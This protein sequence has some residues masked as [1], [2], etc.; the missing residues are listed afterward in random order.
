MIKINVTEDG[1]QKT[2]SGKPGISLMET[3]R[4]AGIEGIV[5][6][7]GGSMSCASCHVFVDSEWLTAMG[8]VS[9]MESDMLD[10]TATEREAGSR[11]SCQIM[12]TDTMDGLSVTVPDE[13]L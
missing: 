7:C 1:Q 4:N 8:E 2:V 5:A 9:E 13:Q 12:L 11:L 6:E 10:C 3:L